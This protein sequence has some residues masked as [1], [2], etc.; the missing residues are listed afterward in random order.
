LHTASML[1]LVDGLSAPTRKATLNIANYRIPLS[2]LSKSN[3]LTA[4]PSR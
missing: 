1:R 2:Q 3:S 4:Q